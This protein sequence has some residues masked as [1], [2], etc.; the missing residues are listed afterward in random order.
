M[1]RFAPL[2]AA[3]DDPD[4]TQDSVGDLLLDRI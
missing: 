4:T 2:Q 1:F 3:T